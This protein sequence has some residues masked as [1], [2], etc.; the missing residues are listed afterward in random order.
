MQ[1]LVGV[2][3]AEKVQKIPLGAEKVQKSNMAKIS[4]LVG[5]Q[6]KDGTRNVSFVLSHRKQRVTLPGNI[7]L[8]PKDLSKRGNIIS[9][10]KLKA[11]DDIIKEYNDKLY[12]AELRITGQEITAKE[13]VKILTKPKD[14]EFF[15]FADEFIANSKKYTHNF[16]VM[17]SSLE[18]FLGVRELLFKDIDYNLLTAY[19]RFLDGHPCAQSGYLG[20]I[21]RI[22]N[23]AVKVYN[24]QYEQPV[25]YSPFNTFKVPKQIT[26]TENRVISLKDLRKVYSFRTFGRMQVAR[27]CY[28]LS[29]CLMGMNTV[30]MYDA[31]PKLID[32]KIC[33]HRKKTRG[34]REDKA[35]IEI[36]VPEIIKPILKRYKDKCRLFNFYKRYCNAASFN[37]F[38]N[39]GLKRIAKELGINRFDFYSARH[40]W[41][42]IARNEVGIDKYTVNEALNHIDPTLK[43]ADVYIKKDFTQIN[44]ANKKVLEYV[45][46]PLSSSLKPQL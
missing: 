18:K 8:C 2:K 39:I 37:R 15:A 10:R 12:D 17:L 19:C 34:R 1:P 6:K 5:K 44:L 11:I 20:S 16:K 29:F 46:S 35:Y 45:F 13:L 38:V 27:D 23:E 43:I 25:P 33:Y 31:D 4:Y 22:Y 21:R 3:S 26:S 24:N 32:G 30:D 36:D 41:A 28:I 14:L 42:S 7:T 9:S 40:T